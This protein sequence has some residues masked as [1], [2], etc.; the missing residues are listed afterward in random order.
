M[1]SRTVG[2]KKFDE[3][4]GR[5]RKDIN[6]FGKQEQQIPIK[7]DWR[8]PSCFK[9]LLRLVIVASIPRTRLL[10]SPPVPATRRRAREIF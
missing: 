6:Y 4:E 5:R 10:H 1:K 2:Q 9:C 3:N 7:G 8:M